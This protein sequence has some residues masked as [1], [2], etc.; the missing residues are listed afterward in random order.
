VHDTFNTGQN[1]F[2]AQFT[3]SRKNMANYLQCTSAAEGYLV[4]ET[5]LTG[6]KQIIELPPAVDP[7][8]A[9]VDNQNIIRVEEVKL[10]SKWRQRVEELLKKG[11]TTVYDQCSQEVRDKLENTVDG[12][13]TEGAAAPQT[14]PEKRKDMCGL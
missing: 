3:Q 9:D 6:K 8:A 5:V 1:K 4:A 10:V 2:A 13:N 12:Q 7:N 14:Y 11:Y